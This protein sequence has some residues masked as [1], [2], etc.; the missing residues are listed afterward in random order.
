[1]K[2]ENVNKMWGGRFTLP[3]AEIMKRINA[4]IDFDKKLYKYDIEGSMVHADMLARQKIITEEENDAIQRGLK[5]IKILIEERKFEF[6]QDLEDIHMNI[7]NKLKELIGDAAGKLHIARSRN[8]QVAL[9]FKMYAR[10]SIDALMNLL[11]KLERE[12][13]NQAEKRY[14][15]MMPGCT[16][17][18]TAQPITFG[19]HLMAYFEMFLRDLKRLKNARKI[20][21]ECPLGAAALG[22][23]PFNIDRHF[24]AEKLS[25]DCPTRNSLDSVSDRD[26]A[27]ELLA[28]VSIVAMHLSRFAEECVIWVSKPYNFI[29][30]P[31]QYTTGSSIMPQKKNPDASE[32]IRGKS[33]R[34]F[35]DL[36]ALLTVMKGLPLAYAKDM[37]EDKEPVFD[38]V[39]NVMLCIEATA[40]MVR[41]ITPQKDNMRRALDQGFPN[42]TDLADYLVK[43][44]NMPFRE[45]HRLTGNIVKMAEEKGLALEE[46]DLADMQRI[47][48]NIDGDVF[49][50]IAMETSLNSRKSYGG[51]A[52][53]M[54]KKAVEEGKRIMEEIIS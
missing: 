35:G 40:D 32:L 39:E 49:K 9:D 19:H 13:L 48:K 6:S 3:P 17:L 4:S 47:C 22:G 51:T 14:D 8:D 2:T 54:V 41:G 26:F 10:D 34:I 38:A 18:Q 15:L 5:Q 33:G 31:E 7:E 42:A 12:F 20:M 16:H 52:P 24:T 23:T 43:K 11:G 37:Q 27:I 1:M 36:Q 53:E 25:F 21:N 28:C 45:A 44:L 50:F 46:M 30:L 29:Q